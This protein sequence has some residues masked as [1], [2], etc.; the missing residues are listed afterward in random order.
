MLDSCESMGL[1]GIYV[2]KNKKG[3]KFW[4]HEWAGSGQKKLIYFSKDPR[5][6]IDL[7]KGFE[8]V[9]SPKTGLPILK[10][11]VKK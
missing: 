8:I 11:K 5:N 10:K 2:F 6:A 9:E 3:E 4:L 1:F 7:P